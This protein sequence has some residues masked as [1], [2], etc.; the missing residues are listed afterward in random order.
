MDIIRILAS[1]Q[2]NRRRISGER[3]YYETTLMSGDDAR[4]V[5]AWLERSGVKANWAAHGGVG[6]C[7]A[8]WTTPA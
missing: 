8:Y 4:E 2:E 6:W 3:W 7:R 5:V 1:A